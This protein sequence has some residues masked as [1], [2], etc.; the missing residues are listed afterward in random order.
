MTE[1]SP[2]QE[3]WR[4]CGQRGFCKSKGWP[5]I[6]IFPKHI[7]HLTLTLDPHFS[8]I[9]AI[10][11]LYIIYLTDHDHVYLDSATLSYS[12][13]V[14]PSH[15]ALKD[16]L[17]VYSLRDSACV[18]QISSLPC[19]HVANDFAAPHTSS[20]MLVSRPFKA[21]NSKYMWASPVEIAD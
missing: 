16:W 4:N 7:H 2:L 12:C 17:I 13:I 20:Y 18:L 6:C 19:A 15:D 21:M 8:L 14:C 3:V 10:I 9:N 5:D 11:P 1:M